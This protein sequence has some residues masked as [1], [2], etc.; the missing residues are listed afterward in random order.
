MAKSVVMAISL[1]GVVYAEA[2]PDDSSVNNWKGFYAGINGGFFLNEVQLTSQQLGFTSPN[3]T[4]NTHSDFSTFFPGLQLGYMYQFTTGLVSGIETN[5]TFNTHQKDTLG[6]RCPDNPNV[7][8]RFS[9]KN[10]RQSSIKGRIGHVWNW[11]KTRFLPYLTAGASFANVGLTYTNEGG[12]YY[13]TTTRQAGSLLGVGIEWA[14]ANNW[15]VR[16]EYSYVDYERTLKLNIPSVYGLIDPNG[17][18]RVNL[19]S[20]TVLVAVNY[21]I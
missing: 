5:V 16:T 2:S 3:E 12:D 1:F 15:S 6:C 9:F 8:D 4:C 17:N 13:S 7:S 10:Q 18:A 11:H 21:W 20:N 14:F 19:S